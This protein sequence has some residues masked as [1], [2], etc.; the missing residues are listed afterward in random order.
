MANRRINKSLLA[1]SMAALACVPATALANG[2]MAASG[3]TTD[4][5]LQAWHE[6]SSNWLMGG[7][8]TGAPETT[9]LFGAPDPLARRNENRVRYLSP[10]FEGL[11]VMG[12]YTTDFADTRSLRGEEPEIN[13]YSLA[14]AYEFGP[15]FL[16]A[17]YERL[18][19]VT[20][21]TGEDDADA[22]SS[23]INPSAWKLGG[24][25][26]M[27]D[28]ILAAAY[29]RLEVPSSISSSRNTW[30][31][32]ARYGLGQAYLM[33]SFSHSGDND[34][35]DM[36]FDSWALGGG[37][38]FSKRTGL[39][40]FYAQMDGDDRS[41]SGL[42]GQGGSQGRGMNSGLADNDN[43]ASGRSQK[44]TGFQVGI[45]HHF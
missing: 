36:S 22:G 14:A 30:H 27:D 15:L 8:L 5:R 16:T 40:A 2:A 18:S 38:D 7:A 19:A 37:W 4:T 45:W 42:F 33:G 34:L 9:P 6:S 41:L 23:R 28:L 43:P 25:Y 44:A 32:G 39:Y 3:A 29:E 35:R 11:R 12:S 21:R 26:Q 10:S 24:A 17:G 20:L 13:A 1:A 31:L